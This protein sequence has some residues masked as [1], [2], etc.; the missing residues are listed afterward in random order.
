MKIAFADE[1]VGQQDV[2]ARIGGKGAGLVRLVEAGANVP[3]FFVLTTDAWRDGAGDELS[4]LVDDALGKLGDGPVAVRSSAVVEDGA[5]V[6][7]AGQFESVLG[8]QG[9]AEVM[10]AVSVCWASAGS[11]RVA[12][13][14]AQHGI[15]P[16]EMAVVVQRLVPGDRSGVMF[17]RDPDDPG[18]ALVSAG[19]GLGEGV[20]QGQVPCDTFRVD[21][22]GTVEVEVA[23]KDEEVVA[24]G[25]GETKSVPVT[26]DRV[27]QPV[28][29]DQQV[30]ELVRVGRDIER[31]AG[32]PQ[33]IEF[34]F[35][36][37]QLYVL[38]TR[39]IT[40]PIP[41]GRRLLWDNSNIV[42]SYSG[43][44]TPLT[45][46]FANRAYT[47]VYEIFHRVMGVDEATIGDMEPVY[48]RMIGL[49]EGRVYY[50]LNAWYL[51][52]Q[53]LPGYSF[54]KGAM[55]T[56]MGVS[57]VASEDDAGHVDGG[58]LDGVGDVPRLARFLWRL[59][60]LDKDVVEFQ[61]LF[62]ETLARNRA[63]DL[64]SMGAEEIL[65]TY[66]RAERDLLW[67]WQPPIVNDF[68][69]M[70]FYAALRSRCQK[71]TGDPET[72]LH[73]R[74]LAGIGLD[75]A[76]P[77]AEL[78]Q[79]AIYIADRDGLREVLL[80][81]TLPGAKL[82]GLLADTGFR[83]RWD[84]W[85]DDYGDRSPDELKL[86]SPTLKDTPEFLLGSLE[87]WVKKP[88][89]PLGEN[90]QK[91]R[92]AAENEAFGLVKGFTERRMFKWILRQARARVATRESL[93][94][95]RTR[96]F[97]FV[98]QMFRAFGDRYAEAG[99]LNDRDD[100][101]YLSLD[102]VL[103]FARGTTVSTS[104]AELAE[105]RK[106][107]FA[108]YR[109]SAGPAER[110]HTWGGVHVNNRFR[111][112]AVK[113]ELDGDSLSGTACSPGVVT[114]PAAV[115]GD[116]RQRPDL[117]GGLLVAHRTDPG[118]VPL[119]PTASGVLVERGSLLSH[120]AVVA[121]ELGLPAIVGIKGLLQWAQDGEM[122]T[123]DGAAG[124]V[125]RQP[126]E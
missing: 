20:V 23:D 14:A 30:R 76:K 86:E 109:A 91:T 94:F 19:W 40:V 42:E 84:Q 34:T 104:L 50:N 116:P 10:E 87:A 118:W 61:A 9:T 13:Y 12:A 66:E 101:F 110:F 80:A 64:D 35:H 3:P 22:Q 92:L 18:R 56:M 79:L 47:I 100:V 121:R 28:L 26:G 33:D 96:I 11:E 120:S 114:A 46:S 98:R 48:K 49:I 78:M 125:R 1:L 75:S 99:V 70:I 107:E 7:W 63:L 58:W 89:R 45:F 17:T 90:E 2:V 83:A 27:S 74:L 111:G 37:G 77:A 15:D 85:M 72:Q 95:E 73:N 69:T 103:G 117:K 67:N 59:T 71:L 124:V 105:V 52:V 62:R 38:Q 39:P 8:V 60:R 44:T 41:W 32:V 106:R 29:S 122:L 65:E 123:M 88:P 54:S 55:E 4:A 102:E 126:A 6:S 68:Y 21:A 93:R 31:R 53:K 115:I 81:D 16:S 43:V 82:D 36:E 97:G 108:G 25:G 113:L 57:E 119:F 24:A 5:K 51:L 112:K